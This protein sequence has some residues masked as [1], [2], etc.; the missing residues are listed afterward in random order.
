MTE[1]IA[2]RP[3]GARIIVRLRQAAGHRVREAGSTV[4][5]AARDLHLSWPTVMAA[6]RTTAREVVDAPLPEVTVL[7]IDEARRGK[8]R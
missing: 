1:S 5:Q 2:Q 4:I 7:S 3:A 8:T 6:F